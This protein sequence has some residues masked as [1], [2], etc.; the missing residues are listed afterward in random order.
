MDKQNEPINQKRKKE[1]K[2]EM[3]NIFSDKRSANQNDPEIPPYT[4]QNG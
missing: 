4:N 2:K 3:S 1:R